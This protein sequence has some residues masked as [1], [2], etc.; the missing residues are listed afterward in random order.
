MEIDKKK[1]DCDVYTL[2]LNLKGFSMKDNI[3][4]TENISINLEK[5]V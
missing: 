2:C 4:K 1:E 3:E 5:T